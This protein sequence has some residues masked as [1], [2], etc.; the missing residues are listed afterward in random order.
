MHVNPIKDTLAIN[1]G[2]LL[3]IMMNDHYKSIDHCVAVDSSRAQI[4][5]PLFVNAS[6]DSVIG[7][8]PQMLKDG[9]KS[10]YKHV[11]HFDYWDYFYP[12]RKPDR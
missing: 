1:I 10:V 12:P 3:K 9:E 6:L 8:F 5:I 11:L 7:A 4:A 2:D